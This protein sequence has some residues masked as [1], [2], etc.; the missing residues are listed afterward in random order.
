MKI[1]LMRLDISSEKIKIPSNW[2]LVIYPSF[3]PFVFSYWTSDGW[4]GTN[5]QKCNKSFGIMVIKVVRIAYFR[6]NVLNKT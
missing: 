6:K 1:Y 2:F 3:F 4:Q 5:F